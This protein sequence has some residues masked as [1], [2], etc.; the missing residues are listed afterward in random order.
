M[1]DNVPGTGQQ[2]PVMWCWPD[3]NG[4]CVT[5]P[6]NCQHGASPVEQPICPATWVAGDG[7]PS[8]PHPGGRWVPPT[9]EPSCVLDTGPD[10][11]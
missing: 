10:L 4:T 5:Q 6:W 11:V 7:T 2:T 1:E 3:G 8:L 9:A